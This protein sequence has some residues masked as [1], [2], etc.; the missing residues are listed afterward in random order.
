[1][2]LPKGYLEEI[3]R[4]FSGELHKKWADLVTPLLLIKLLEEKLDVKAK[5]EKRSKQD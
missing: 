4:C 5:K 3:E 1:M 2:K